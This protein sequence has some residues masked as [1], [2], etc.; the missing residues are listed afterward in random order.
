MRKKKGVDEVAVLGVEAVA[1]KEPFGDSTRTPTAPIN[2]QPKASYAEAM[3]Q[4]EAG[5]LAKAVLTEEGWVM[6]SDRGPIKV[7]QR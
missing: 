3:K 6:P 4:R 1:G 2:Q 7:I 5:T